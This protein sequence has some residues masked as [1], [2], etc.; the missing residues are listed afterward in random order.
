M[1]QILLE[2]VWVMLEISYSKKFI[3]FRKKLEFNAANSFYSYYFFLA[4]SARLLLFNKISTGI[5]TNQLLSE[6][7]YKRH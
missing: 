2:M 3:I 5:K 6:A 4:V 1:L 7:K